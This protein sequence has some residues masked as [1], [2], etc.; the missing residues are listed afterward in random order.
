MPS[1][2]G[3]CFEVSQLMILKLVFTASLFDAQHWRGQWKEYTGKFSCTVRKGIAPDFSVMQTISE[4]VVT[5]YL[6]FCDRRVNIQQNKKKFFLLQQNNPQQHV[7]IYILIASNKCI[8]LV[9]TN[10]CSKP[11]S[12]NMHIAHLCIEVTAL[13]RLNF[14]NFLRVHTFLYHMFS[15]IRELSAFSSKW[16]RNLIFY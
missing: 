6:L 15:A 4:L 3:V 11:L 1:I 5:L 7:K 12:L 8:L 2:E 16:N 13:L 9:S 14:S 10:Y